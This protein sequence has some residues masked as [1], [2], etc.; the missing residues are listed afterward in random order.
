MLSYTATPLS[1]TTELLARVCVERRIFV[2]DDRLAFLEDWLE[3]FDEDY[4]SGRMEGY[5]LDLT[6]GRLW[7]ALDLSD[8]SPAAYRDIALLSVQ[9]GND[10]EAAEAFRTLTRTCDPITAE[11][12]L[13]CSFDPSAWPL[14]ATACNAFTT[15]E[16]FSWKITDSS[17]STQTDS[18]DESQH[19]YH[20]V[21]SN[22]YNSNESPRLG[23][24][25]AHDR[26]LE[27]RVAEETAG[28]VRRSI[29]SRLPEPLDRNDAIVLLT[30]I[31]AVLTYKRKRIPAFRAQRLRERLSPL[32]RRV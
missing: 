1:E 6:G 5:V 30:A 21:L 25:P 4:R 16:D 23:K 18:L 19:V 10:T 12:I 28:L 11:N 15:H 26:I 20:C 31:E 13:T 7:A 32:S 14:L 27:L 29:G 2:G 22:G 17:F 24:E 3:P 8:V 9:P